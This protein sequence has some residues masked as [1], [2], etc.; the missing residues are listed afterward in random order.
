[1]A[2]KDLRRAAAEG[3]M[4]EVVRLLQIGNVNIN[5]CDSVSRNI[6]VSLNT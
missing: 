6:Y 5:G 2:E 4:Q 1:M 3:N